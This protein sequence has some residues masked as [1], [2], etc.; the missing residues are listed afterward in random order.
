MTN[1]TFINAAALRGTAKALRDIKGD[2]LLCGGNFND[3]TWHT[4][5]KHDGVIGEADFS[6]A[7]NR[8]VLIDTLTACV[9]IKLGMVITWT[10]DKATITCGDFVAKMPADIVAE[11]D[12]D[13]TCTI[14]DTVE[15]SDS[16]GA[17]AQFAKKSEQFNFILLL[18]GAA[19]ATDGVI[20]VRV[21]Y[22]SDAVGNIE[23]YIAPDAL[24]GHKEG[25]G[26]AL[27]GAEANAETVTRSINTSSGVT[28]VA[29]V[30]IGRRPRLVE[31]VSKSL[32]GKNPRYRIGFGSME[33]VKA[34][35]L[36]CAGAAITK[37]D[38]KTFIALDHDKDAGTLSLRPYAPDAEGN[39]ALDDL[40]KATFDV[41]C[42]DFDVSSSCVI[43]TTA[44]VLQDICRLLGTKTYVEMTAYEGMMVFERCSTFILA[45]GCNPKYVKPVTPTKGK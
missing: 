44:G 5:V 34:H 40:T 31:V 2:I 12:D 4:L 8:K 15:Y 35:A 21:E 42:P 3:K 30:K 13:V 26:I 29:R 9:P 11:A 41:D 20:L 32:S 7:V 6:V 33:L 23:H 27:Y 17:L 28:K 14:I 37:G 24:I 22:N 19:Y 38:R 43:Y 25:N 36:V 1:R 10:D 16:L 45:M 39:N 18:G